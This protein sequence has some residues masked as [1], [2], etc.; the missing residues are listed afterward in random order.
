MVRNVIPFQLFSKSN[1]C[2]I[3]EKIKLTL[4]SDHN[5]H[6][7]RG[8]PV[9][10]CYAVHFAKSLSKKE[11]ILQHSVYLMELL[12]PQQYK[13]YKC[14]YTEHLTTVT[15]DILTAA[16]KTEVHQKFRLVS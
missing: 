16:L 9:P 15:L 14:I 2:E 3:S 10:I 5:G 8:R 12:H 7:L 6:H 11:V 13:G 1:K 4:W